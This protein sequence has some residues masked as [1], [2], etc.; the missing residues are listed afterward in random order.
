[1]TAKADWFERAPAIIAV[2]NQRVIGY[3]GT[4]PMRLWKNGR[5][6]DAHWFKGFMVIPEFRNGPIGFALVREAM[7][8]VGDVAVLTVQSASWR[9]FQAAGL[10]L[11]GAVPNYLR[12]L[13]PA[14]V[15]Q[16]L[17]LAKIPLKSFPAW[18]TA[19]ARIAQ[20]T[21]V[22]A[23]GGAIG[24]FSAAALAAARGSGEAVGSTE[25]IGD[26]DGDLGEAWGRMRAGIRVGQVR[27]AAYVRA[28]YSASAR[29]FRCSASRG[30]SGVAFTMVRRPREGGDERLSGLS[31]AV[32]SDLIA[33]L[34]AP[35]L[36][37]SALRRAEADA[38]E[39][40]ADALVCSPSHPALAPL[41]RRRSWLAI[42][43]NLHFLARAADVAPSGVGDWWLMRADGNSDEGF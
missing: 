9:L 12:I 7:K 15:A 32:L 27:D 38:R 30:R 25:G 6:A 13:R 14:R 35:A 10:R 26:H 31:V 23:V 16:R 20:K 18:V 33:P 42:P 4:L 34:D 2:Q 43:A 40:G 24:G 41:L 21:G 39:L 22:A 37:L 8:H 28:R 3:L 5:E 1:M 17:D 19:G 11:A 36:L 29:Q